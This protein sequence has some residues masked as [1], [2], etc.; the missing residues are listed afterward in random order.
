MRKGLLLNSVPIN[1]DGQQLKFEDEDFAAMQGMLPVAGKRTHRLGLEMIRN[2]PTLNL[3]EA[4]SAAYL[5]GMNDTLLA[6][7][8]NQPLPRKEPGTR[9]KGE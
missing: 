6:I 2:P 1:K 3:R 7:D 5:Q 4:L 9:S 8:S